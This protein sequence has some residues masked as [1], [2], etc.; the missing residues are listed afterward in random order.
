M[1]YAQCPCGGTGHQ[2]GLEVSPSVINELYFCHKCGG[3]FTRP[4]R[5]PAAAE[6]KA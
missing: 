4:M 5:G 6:V 2:V 3:R 1:R